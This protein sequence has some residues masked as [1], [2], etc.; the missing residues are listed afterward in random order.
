MTPLQLGTIP[1]GSTVQGEVNFE[2]LNGNLDTLQAGAAFVYVATGAASSGGTAVT[3]SAVGSGADQYRYK[4]SFTAPAA[5]SY[6]I[7]CT[8]GS[9]TS[10]NSVAG[11]VVAQ[12]T[13]G[14]V[15]AN[16]V[17]Q[18]GNPIAA[19]PV[20]R[21]TR[22][23]GVTADGV[24]DDAAALN[25]FLAS[26]GPCKILV[27]GVHAPRPPPS[28]FIPA[29]SSKAS[30]AEP[31][32][33]N[34]GNTNLDCIV[35]A[36]P[37]VSVPSMGSGS[38]FFGNPVVYPLQLSAA[39]NSTIATSMTTLPY[40]GDLLGSPTGPTNW[41]MSGTLPSFSTLPQGGLHVL[42]SD[43]NA[44]SGNPGEIVLITAASYN[45]TSHVTTYTIARGQLGS[46][47]T[48]HVA[49]SVVTE[50]VIDEDIRL[51]NLTIDSKNFPGTTVQNSYTQYGFCTAM[52][53]L[54]VR[55]LYLENVSVRDHSPGFKMLLGNIQGKLQL[56]G[57]DCRQNVANPLNGDDAV[58]FWG[59]IEKLVMRDC[60]LSGV[61]SPLAINIGENDFAN[62][63][64]A[65]A[66]NVAY[67][68][69]GNV[70]C[71]DVDG[72]QATGTRGPIIGMLGAANETISRLTIK[73]ALVR[74]PANSAAALANNP[75]IVEDYEESTTITTCLWENWTVETASNAT[76]QGVS[77]PLASSISKPRIS[78]STGRRQTNWFARSRRP[79]MP[80]MYP[81]SDCA[82]RLLQRFKARQ[83]SMVR[84]F[85][86]SLRDLKRPVPLALA[87]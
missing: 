23:A 13:T 20:Y 43:P 80:R 58:H 49:N 52:T 5:S 68:S 63:V 86:L 83:L 34:Y 14:L 18:G 59:P 41:S 4:F 12:F 26:A 66:I 81:L 79:S 45:A 7:I 1:V 70:A 30:T 85:P 71:I 29:R 55:N 82:R 39:I 8:A 42:I 56:T 28:S 9:V 64:A 10:G 15:Q 38:S 16:S 2:D 11:L 32:I 17:Q 33:I 84:C 46:I 40:Q 65:A 60:W 67:Q 53:F 57:I 27:D 37:R 47:A 62:W 78:A 72:L 75:A 73:D 24:T 74:S 44:D 87:P 36:N 19:K 77:A 50:W 22:I 21:S 54:G 3:L 61:D 25:S 69:A 48:T 6:Q 35:N 76:P 31:R 51:K